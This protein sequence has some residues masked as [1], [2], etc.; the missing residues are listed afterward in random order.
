MI[1]RDKLSPSSFS[2]EKRV[3][4]RASKLVI[5]ISSA[6]PLILAVVVVVSNPISNQ[7]DIIRAY[8]ELSHHRERRR[9]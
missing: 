5:E 8:S 1:R 3:E 9:L 2:L 4:I 6:T 7:H